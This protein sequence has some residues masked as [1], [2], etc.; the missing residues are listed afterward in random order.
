M[1]RYNLGGKDVFYPRI[2]CRLHLYRTAPLPTRV[3]ADNAIIAM[4]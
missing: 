3:M 2:E 4:L 1:L